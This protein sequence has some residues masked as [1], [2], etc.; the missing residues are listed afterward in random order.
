MRTIITIIVSILSS[1]FLAGA[2]FAAIEL[3]CPKSVPEGEAFV[4]RIVSDGPLVSVKLRWLSKDVRPVVKKDGDQMVAWALLGISMHERRKGESFKLDAVVQTPQ[5][6]QAFSRTVRRTKKKYEEQWLDVARK[7]TS[8]KDYELKRHHKEQKLIKAAFARVSTSR[9]F[10]VPLLKPIEG[11]TSSTYG[12]R[13]F[14]NKIPKRPHSGWDIA[15]PTGTQIKACDDGLVVLAGD[16]FFAGNSVY[17]DHGHGVVSMYFHMSKIGVA[18]GQ[19]VL[20]GQS[21][22]EV[23]A[24]GRVTGPHLHWGVSVLGELV[25]P[26]LLVK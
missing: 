25:D 17:I 18:E 26:S 24:T 19:A 13:R 16:H 22:G 23:G 10:T 8:L 7:Y 20:R 21:I 3:D 15:A 4:V 2:C 11:R 12:L 14:F 9:T 6:E 5:G 1:L